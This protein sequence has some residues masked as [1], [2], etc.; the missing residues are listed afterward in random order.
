MTMRLTRRMERERA[1]RWPHR[2]R[3]IERGGG[4]LKGSYVHV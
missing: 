4:V 3:Y 2:R 1:C